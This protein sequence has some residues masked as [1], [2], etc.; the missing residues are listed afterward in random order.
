MIRRLCTTL[1]LAAALPI[2]AHAAVDI[3]I[4]VAPPPLPVYTQPVIPA[5]GYIWTPGY[6]RWSPGFGEYVWVPGTWISPPYTGALWTPGYW[7]WSG[8]VYAWHGG[9]WGTHVGFYGGVNY[10]FGYVGH[11]YEGGYWNGGV[12]NYNRSVNN[13]NTS[14][15]RN[16]YEKTVVVNNTRVSYNGGTGGLG[17]R[18]TPEERAAQA[19]AHAQPTPQQRQHEQVALRS[20][21]QRVSVNH[22]N[23]TVA[24]LPRPNV[25]VEAHGGGHPG[26]PGGAARPHEQ[27]AG[28]PGGHAEEPHGGSGGGAHHEGGHEH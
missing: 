27:A 4:T 21:E 25:A 16:V 12:F 24:A 6:W 13:V 14:I 23:P 10:G 18:P 5:A 8:G 7:G 3:S 2:A 19:E 22:G 1:A 11:G 20:P 15:V 28:H 9:Y 17:E 26:G